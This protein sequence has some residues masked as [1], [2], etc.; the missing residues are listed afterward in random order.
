MN[1]FVFCEEPVSETYHQ[2]LRFCASSTLSMTLVARTRG[3][4]SD[5]IFAQLRPCFLEQVVTDR[6]PGTT[7]FGHTAAVRRYSTKAPLERVLSERA[8]G[9]YSW[10]G[11]LP[12]DPC[13]YR[14]DETVLLV[15]V[16]HERDA[17]LLLTDEEFAT[18][19]RTYPALAATLRFEG[20]AD[21]FWP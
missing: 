13:F 14:A 3:E 16:S 8:D 11:D 9:L 18:V 12:E 10:V 7:L 2:L 17:A 4:I 1:R 19:G 21:G 6:W 20:V 5:S 15:T